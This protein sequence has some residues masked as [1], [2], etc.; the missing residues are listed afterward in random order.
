MKNTPQTLKGFR[1]FLPEDMIIRNYVKNIFIEVFENFG[2]QPL[3]TPTLEYLSTLTGKY[4]SDA[5][6]LLYSFTDKGDSD[7]ILLS[8]RPKS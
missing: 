3:E 7:M 2:F 6:K 5:D 4:G 1:D 8:P